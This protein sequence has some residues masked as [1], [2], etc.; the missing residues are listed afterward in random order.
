[1]SA[2]AAVA[3][4]RSSA[5]FFSEEPPW[6]GHLG[7]L[8]CDVPT[9]PDHFGANLDQLFPKRCEGPVLHGLGQRQ[10][11]PW[12]RAVETAKAWADQAEQRARVEHIGRDGNSRGVIYETK[13]K[14]KPAKR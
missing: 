14:A 12:D 7:K 11:V 9:V 4:R 5:G 6:N 3:A 2:Q 8:E 1:M 13:R 10:R